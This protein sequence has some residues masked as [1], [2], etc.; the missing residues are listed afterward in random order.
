MRWSKPRSGRQGI[1]LTVVFSAA[2]VMALTAC[3]GPQVNQ[4]TESVSAGTPIGQAPEAVSAGASVGARFPA[5]LAGGSAYLGTPTQLRAVNVKTGQLTLIRPQHPVLA[6]AAV[7]SQPLALGGGTGPAVLWPFLV[8]APGGQAA[9]EL[10]SV[11]A[12]GRTTG[13]P[14]VALPAWA[15]DSASPPRVEAVGAQNGVVVLNVAHSLT[16]S[17]LGV[18]IATGRQLWI[19]DQFSAGVVAGATAVGQEPDPASEQAS[20]VTGVNVSNGQQTWTG[21]RGAQFGI[22]KAGPELVAVDTPAPTGPRLVQ[23]LSTI[24]GAVVEQLPL[25]SAAPTR[26]VFDQASVT[27]CSAPAG[28]AGG[29]RQA[30][31]IDANNGRVLWTMPNSTNPRNV[32]SGGEAPLITAGWHGR[33]YGATESSTIAYDARTGEPQLFLPGPSPS[34]VDD[35]TGLALS[36][37]GKQVVARSVAPTKN[38][39]PTVSKCTACQAPS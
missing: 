1:S 17:A 30:V 5:I 28:S 19:R 10:T 39:V 33:F 18:D 13:N 26:C 2:A 4:N 38:Y 21:L 35:N 16:H 24:N 29:G 12:D 3:S 31:G 27:A 6:N 32:T 25:H 14:I 9:I 23:L 20:H 36:S 34:S 7:D 8:A 37:D 22:S 11:G 15:S